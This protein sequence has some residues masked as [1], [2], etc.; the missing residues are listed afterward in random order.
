MLRD[1]H[2]ELAAKGLRVLGVSPQDE[3]SHRRFAEAHDLPF[4]LIAD[5]TKKLAEA[6]EV[7]GPFGIIRR[8]TY[9]IDRQAKIADAVRADL[10]ISRHEEFVRKALEASL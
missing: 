6:F 3:D 10:R 1:L 9:L 8:T 5:P 7:L 4:E 2:G